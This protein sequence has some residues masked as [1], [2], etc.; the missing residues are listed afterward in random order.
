MKKMT[1]SAALS[2]ARSIDAARDRQLQQ[3]ARQCWKSIVVPTCK[4]HGFE[5]RA[6]MG[7]YLLTTS[8]GQHIYDAQDAARRGLKLKRLFAVLDIPIDQ[9]LPSKGTLGSWMCDFIPRST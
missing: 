4:K 7:T 9:A 2:K 5:F 3:L 1:P 8:D 6:G